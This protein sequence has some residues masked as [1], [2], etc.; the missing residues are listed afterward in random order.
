MALQYQNTFTFAYPI[1]DG[2]PVSFMEHT[3]GA[4]SCVIRWSG[5]DYEA[6]HSPSDLAGRFSDL[7]RMFRSA[8]Q[9]T[10][11]VMEHHLF[12]GMDV[13]SCEEYYNYG[14][15]HVLPLLL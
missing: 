10:D 13:R 4:V 9:Y 7:Y 2:S 1:V 8:A 5:I 3:D 12:R 11:L 15:D 6:S 14:V